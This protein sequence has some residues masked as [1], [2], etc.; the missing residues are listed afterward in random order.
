MRLSDYEQKI[1]KETAGLIFGKDSK[2]YIFGSRA[3]DDLKGGDIDIYIETFN[4]LGKLIEMKIRF[5]IELEKK[6]GNKKSMW[7]LITG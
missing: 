2:V 1:I 5:L 4:N 3:N 6:S 7:L